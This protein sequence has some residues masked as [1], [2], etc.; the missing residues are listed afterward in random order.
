MGLI[1]TYKYAIM[2]GAAFLLGPIV[3]LSCGFLLRLGIVE[4]IPTFLALAAGE[5]IGDVLWYY[6]GHRYGEQ[7]V[8]RFGRYV[9]ISPSMVLIVKELF[10]RYHDT[11]LIASKLTAGLGFAV[12]VLFT[13][14]LSRVPFR[15]YMMINIGGQIVLTSTLVTLG[16]YLGDIY[17]TVGG[18]FQK[19]SIFGI[20]AFI[21]L[22]LFG[23]SHYLRKRAEEKYRE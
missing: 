20:T 23:F 9:G 1:L 7:F 18:I 11:I 16:F 5:L 21:F 13:A 14:G 12:A 8:Q 3:S 17:L 6:L 15:R 2:P 22:C 10:N 19:V 4:W